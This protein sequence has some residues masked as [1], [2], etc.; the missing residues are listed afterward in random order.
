MVGKTLW[1]SILV[2]GLLAISGLGFAAFTASYQV[3]L[4]GTA[5]NLSITIANDNTITSNTYVSCVASAQVGYLN[6]TA[7]PF[8]PGDWCEVF[9]NITN[10]GNV[11]ATVLANWPHSGIDACFDWTVIYPTHNPNVPPTGRGLQPGASEKFQFALGLD[12][13]A[14]NSCENHVAT[15]SMNFTA[16]S[17]TPST[18]FP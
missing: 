3:N 8:A 14:G 5:G 18:P 7:G 12:P 4:Q 2:V 16:T 13:S 9:G 15:V 6:I 11:P 10:T 17:M 1:T